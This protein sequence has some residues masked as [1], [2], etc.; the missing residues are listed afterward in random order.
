MT[1]KDYEKIAGYINV[2]RIYMKPA[3]QAQEDLQRVTEDFME[4]LAEE[5]PRFNADIFRKA[6]GF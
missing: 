1:R 3:T 4:L 5:N 6:C 2:L